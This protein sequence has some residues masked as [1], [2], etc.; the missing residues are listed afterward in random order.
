M[1]TL[2]GGHSRLARMA[3]LDTK[4]QPQDTYYF[5]TDD[6][7]SVAKKPP[8]PAADPAEPRDS[9]SDLQT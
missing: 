1:D 8:P 7:T 6:P 9:S 5:T 4:D 3:T 2:D